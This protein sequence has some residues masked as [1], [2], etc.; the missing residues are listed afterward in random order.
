M[1]Q[2]GRRNGGRDMSAGR[3]GSGHESLAN[4]GSRYQMNHHQYM[5]NTRP[6]LETLTLLVYLIKAQ[7]YL[8]SCLCMYGC[9]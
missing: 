5:D 8:E 4:Y 6:V 7:K 9:I 1:S 3:A 2:G